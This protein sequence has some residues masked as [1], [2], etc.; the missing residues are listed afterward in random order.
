MEKFILIC[1]KQFFSF[2]ISKVACCLGSKL[3][4]SISY[5]KLV[6]VSILYLCFF[7][8]KWNWGL[9]L[10]ELWSVI[11]CWQV[12]KQSHREVHGLNLCQVT[13][14]HTE[15]FRGFPQSLQVSAE[16]IPWNSPWP[17]PSTSLIV[18]LSWPS[19]NLIWY[20][21][22][23]AVETVFEIIQ[24]SIINN[25]LLMNIIPCSWW[26]LYLS[27]LLYYV[28]SKVPGHSWSSNWGTEL[29]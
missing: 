1:N 6:T 12:L 24:E 8:I 22:S 14:N 21:V 4:L 7:R 19:Y 29:W 11:R 20:Y 27:W 23:S 17:F 18:Y 16:I 9:K 15:V 13:G 10:H 25:F 2:C 5:G 28:S 26:Q 3:A